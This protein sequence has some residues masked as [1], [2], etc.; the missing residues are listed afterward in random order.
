MAS[1]SRRACSKACA[2]DQARRAAARRATMATPCARPTSQTVSSATPP[3]PAGTAREVTEHRAVTYR[4]HH[5][6][7]AT[8]AA[9]PETVTAHVQYGP[10]LRATAVYL[11]V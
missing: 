7:G 9:F 1:R 2:A 3:P 8:T 11:N 6:W 10:R 4:C 5:C